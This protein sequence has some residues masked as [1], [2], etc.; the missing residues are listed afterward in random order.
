MQYK[1]YLPEPHPLLAAKPNLVILL[2]DLIE[3]CADE[4]KNF[5]PRFTPLIYHGDKRLRKAS[6][7]RRIEGRL[8]RYDA[9]FDGSEENGNKVV[10]TSLAT[11]VKLHGPNALVGFRTSPQGF[12]KIE[13]GKCISI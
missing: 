8:S 11:L 3:Q 7:H 4:I 6:K 2:P 9:I 5:C 10:I 1:S 12:S 13:S